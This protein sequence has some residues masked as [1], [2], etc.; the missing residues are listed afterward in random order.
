MKVRI[1]SDKN[2]FYCLYFRNP[3]YGQ[4]GVITGTC[5]VDHSTDFTKYRGVL[6]PDWTPDP[7]NPIPKIQVS[8]EE[9][10]A[11]NF[12][13]RK[14]RGKIKRPIKLLRDPREVYPSLGIESPLIK[15]KKKQERFVKILGDNEKIRKLVDQLFS[16]NKRSS[17]EGRKIRKE[18][19]KLGFYVSRKE[20]ENG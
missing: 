13:K 5:L 15:S 19:R 18:L 2:C 14:W 16:L 8:F 6:C 12:L 4:A 17:P 11:E 10:E 9:K 1:S 3:I 20:L 7:K